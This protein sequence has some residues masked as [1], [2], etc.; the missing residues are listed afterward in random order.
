MSMQLEWKMGW[1][2]IQLSG[3]LGATLFT[4]LSIFSP[5]ALASG[6]RIP[7]L[8]VTGL[9]TAN[10]LVA[11]TQELGA[12]PYNPA[13]MGF[14]EDHNLV[15]G[16]VYIDP[17][18]HVTPSNGT[19]ADNIGKSSFLVPNFYYMADIKNTPWK[20][21]LGVNAPFGLEVKWPQNTFGSISSPTLEPALSKIEMININPN[22]VYK[23]DN[24][25]IAFGID[26]Y[27]VME[28]ALNSYTTTI[29]GTGDG[30]GWNVAVLQIN[31]PLSL[32]L[33]YRSSVDTDIT[34]S[35]NTTPVTT[36]IEF[37]AILQFGGRYEFSNTWAVEFDIDRTYWKSFDVVD[38]KNTSG[39]T[40]TTS[41]NNWT[42]ATAYRLGFTH[43]LSPKTRLRFGYTLDKTPQG[44]DR[45][46]ARI[47]DADRQLYSVGVTHNFENWQLDAG[48]M[49]VKF[50]DRT[51]NTSVPFGTYGTETN[52]TSVFNG[53][54]ES[55]A[56][57]LGIGFTAKF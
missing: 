55:D 22:F 29:T 40:L 43:Q 33:S 6:F 52:G 24:T 42:N 53:T 34:G 16:F 50:D 54:Y 12:L 10:A 21:G 23:K 25:S 7:E 26:Y 4:L 30:Y 46:S 48:Y 17:T 32:G 49:Y 37:P 28:V 51:Y 36:S 57:L 47:P 31:G 39:T 13:A 20:W 18:Q 45:Y 41:T 8:S 38:I 9:G 3:V 44:D 5:N 11:N 1:K 2:T 35:L 15:T 27:D 56:H 19:P 14:H